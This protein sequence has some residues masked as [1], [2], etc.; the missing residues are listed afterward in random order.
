MKSKKGKCYLCDEESTSTEHTPARCFFP[1]DKRKNLVTVRSCSKHNQDTTLDDEYVKTVIS[2]AKGTNDI[3]LRHFK[4]KG[5]RAFRKNPKFASLVSKNP[6]QLNFIK[7]N[8]ETKAHTYE[9]D[10]IRFDRTLRKI[11]YGL[12]YYKYKQTWNNELEI[13]TE[14][15]ITANHETD[16]IAERLKYSSLKE[17]IE[18]EGCNPDVFKFSFLD[19]KVS[20]HKFLVMKF[21]EWFEIWAIPNDKTTLPSLD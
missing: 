20:H 8:E 21:Y 19:F 17:S 13:A 2:M 11:A 4:D 6:K 14:N 7:G 16:V 15:L 5:L 1:S 10:R 9:V 3:A 12:Y 18:F